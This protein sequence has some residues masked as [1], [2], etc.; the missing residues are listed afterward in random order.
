MTGH[1]PEEAIAR[2]S[3]IGRQPPTSVIPLAFTLPLRNQ[4]ELQDLLARIYDPSD[5]LYGRYLTSQEFT[6]R[7]G[8]TQQDYDA[9]ARYATSQG[10]R[11]TQTHSNRLVLDV[12]AP[13]SRVESAFNLRLDRY[14]D[15]KGRQFYAPDRDPEVPLPVATLLA[16]VVG[17]DTAAVWKT[18]ALFSPAIDSPMSTPLQIGTGPGGGLTPSDLVTAYNLGGVAATGTGQTLALFELDGY[19]ASDV[20]AYRSYYGLSNVP[21]SNVLIDGFSGSPGSGASEVTLDIELMMALAPGATTIMVYEGPNSNTGV[22]DTY[23]RIA[24]DNHAKQISTSWGL[25][26]GQN[27]GAVLTTENAIFQ[28]MASQGQSIFAASGDSGAYDNGST[29]SVDDPAS[30]PFMTGTGGTQLFVGSGLS[31][32]KESSWNVNGTA[33]GGAGGGGGSSVWSIPSWQTGTA[34]AASPAMRNVPDVSLNADQNTGY[35]IYY[36]GGWWIFGGTS[37]AA[38]LWAAFTARVNQSRLSAAAAPLGFANPV[39][40]QLA[41]SSGYA[42]AFHDVAD[43]STNLYYPAVTGYDNSTGWGSFNGAGL[44]AALTTVA[45]PTSAPA[46][47]TGVTASPGN[48]SITVSWSA[49]AGAASY[50]LYRGTSSGGETLLAPALSS[51]VFTDNG[52]ANG[53]TYYY[54]V[55]AS[56][57][58]GT[59]VLSA[60]VSATPA[61]PALAI[62]G[63]PSLVLGS[64]TAQLTWTTNIPA[65]SLVA[66]GTSSGNLNRSV[67]SQTMVTSHVITLT[68]LA[69]RTTYYIR[70]TSASGTATVSSSV[71]SFRTH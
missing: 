11:V 52:L 5:P 51:T 12:A 14:D 41:K 69:R 20:A 60:E 18:H 10:F 6:D 40:Y 39:I 15:G 13:S 61:A 53:V 22:I 67:S 7:F 1:V 47:P 32:L 54:Q 42:A 44:F 34:S 48:T 26:E 2:S 59:S 63:G 3:H 71:Y 49:T 70:L 19:R 37:C 9:V 56:N 24:T 68:G 30:Q 66:Y 28:Q 43:G 57:V 38:P 31:Y 46:A 50:N 58:I 21:L 36:N 35:S 23:N 17:L 25:S 27:S 4:P 62:T 65:T 33:G 55:S 64:G 29:L 8:P 16:G 45:P